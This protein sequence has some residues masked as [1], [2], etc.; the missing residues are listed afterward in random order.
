VLG[1]P[2][3]E[4]Q[5]AF[6]G[7]IERLLSEGQFVATYKYA[8]LVALADLAVKHGHDDGAELDLSIRSIGEQF[9]ELY[10]R[11]CAP[12]GGGVRDGDGI[13]IQNRG[14]QAA[15]LGIVARL[16]QRHRS[17]SEARRGIGWQSATTAASAVVRN[18]PLWR[19]QQ[20]RGQSLEC[21][22]VESPRSDHIRL[23][24]GV[25]AH[26][27]R[28]HGMIVRLAQSEWLRF[29]QSLP[30]NEHILGPT[31]D[32]DGFLFGSERGALT[33]MVEPLLEIQHGQ[34]LY[35][36]KDLQSIEVDHF[37][38]WG[39]YPRDLAHNLA[40]AHRTCNR[41]KSDLLAA[42][43][44]LE[45]WLRR[46][47]DHDAALGEAGQQAGLI[48]DAAGTHSVATWAYSHGAQL[49]SGAWLQDDEVIPLTGQWRHLLASHADGQSQI[50]AAE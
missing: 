25:A 30:D 12:Y 4:E 9:I 21:I 6:L 18:M 35:C 36:R 8:L 29:I 28:F 37:I 43:T 11:Q 17:L 33:R 27:R 40:L 32:L 24:P 48:V 22:Y 44:H 3:A 23:L 5:L 19:L 7:Q 26:L 16:R 49:H 31:A 1:G 46:N 13:P 42:E 47:A 34:C 50:I 10:W 45:H 15:I 2:T 20:I 39:R 14:Q 38:P 41:Q